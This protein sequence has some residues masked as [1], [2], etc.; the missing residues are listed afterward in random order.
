VPL[1]SGEGS[2]GDL[3]AQGAVTVGH[4]GN[5]DAGQ[6]LEVTA[7]QAYEAIGRGYTEFVRE[8]HAVVAALLKVAD[9][10]D[11]AEEEI[12]RQIRAILAGIGE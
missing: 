3:Q 9:N 2:Q 11:G 5:W 4:L 1:T 12:A 6:P 7:R 8:C 10:Y